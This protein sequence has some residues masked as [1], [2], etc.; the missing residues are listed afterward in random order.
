MKNLQI[1]PRNGADDEP[2]GPPPELRASV[3]RRKASA[4]CAEQRGLTSLTKEAS[5]PT[6]V[7][8][9]EEICMVLYGFI[10]ELYGFIGELYGCI[11]DYYG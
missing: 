6:F 7:G 2:Q 5:K 3:R 10:R 1:S 8:F 9:E 4:G 11:V